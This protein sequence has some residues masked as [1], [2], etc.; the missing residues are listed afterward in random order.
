MN[1]KTLTAAALLALAV[2]PAA[3][4]PKTL[5]PAGALCENPDG[6]DLPETPL[7]EAKAQS[8][9]PL[10]EAAGRGDAEGVRALIKSGVSLN[11]R[12]AD[13]STAL[14]R[15]AIAA[16]ARTVE[17]LLA[18]GASVET[19]DRMGRTAL[20]YALSSPHRRANAQALLR[21]GAKVNCTDRSGHTPLM[22]ALR[23][24]ASVD[25][26]Q[27]LLTDRGAWPER[28]DHRGR[29]PMM[30]ACRYAGA[31]AVKALY[32]AGAEIRFPDDGG[33]TPIHYAAQNSTGSGASIVSFL[34]DNRADL[35]ARDG[36]GMT[37]LAVAAASG[38]DAKLI[39]T[40]LKAGADVESADASDMTPL[41]HAASSS[42]AQ[43]LAIV[44][45]LAAAGGSLSRRD[46]LGRDAFL[47]AVGSSPSVETVR[48]ID[49]AGENAAKAEK[50]RKKNGNAPRPLL[51][52]A[53]NPTDGAPAIIDY[54][55]K[56]GEALEERDD[57]GR[58]AFV[59]AL[60]YNASPAAAQ[61]LAE[62]GADRRVRWKG[63]SPRQLLRYNDAMKPE[64]KVALAA[65]LRK[66]NP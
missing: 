22:Y 16:D 24:G 39:R 10:M 52:A 27:E 3:A 17:I 50:D 40:F 37:P 2:V 19:T 62:G 6:P 5:A 49:N 44:K 58:T 13:G 66:L 51:T 64:D 28:R 26:V 11:A 30:Y 59:R 54:L 20:M 7:L 65:F 25:F 15:A 56:R 31:D 4:A 45:I 12:A 35:S 61:A 36:G 9:T 57:L 42:G 63:A 23:A 14:M 38:S 32:G 34:L 53:L 33:R 43:A 29:T 21:A 55:L 18:A 41:M 60:R 8:T 1:L 48:W 47:C 46:R